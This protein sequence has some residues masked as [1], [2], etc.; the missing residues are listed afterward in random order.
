MA[1]PGQTK[2]PAGAS[3]SASVLQMAPQL[4]YYGIR[5]ALVA[6]GADWGDPSTIRRLDPSFS[7][8]RVVA[9]YADRRE[10]TGA[11]SQFRSAFEQTYRSSLG[12][13]VVP[14]LGHDAALLLVRALAETVPTRPRALA[15]GLARLEEV[16]GA[17]G[18]LRVVPGGAVARRVRLRAVEDRD[19]TTTS[20][21]EARSWL[22]SAGRL[23]TARARSRR[24]R[25]LEA[26]REAEIPLTTGSEASEEE[27][28][29]R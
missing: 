7:Q 19:L 29:S 12:D 9:A 26:V 1:V 2:F 18:L 17:T 11:W 20:A 13:N 6:G 15:R 27:G 22:A 4:S 25:A 3:G 16:E 8:F 5:G 10:E 21:A 28:S 14:G 24:S 23:E